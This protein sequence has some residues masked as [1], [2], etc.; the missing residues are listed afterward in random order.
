MSGNKVRSLN[1]NRDEA[2]TNLKYIHEVLS[3]MVSYTKYCYNI[4][5]SDIHEVFEYPTLIKQKWG[6]S[7]LSEKTFKFLQLF[8][9]SWLSY[10]TNK[11]FSDDPVFVYFDPEWHELIKDKLIPCL[12]SMEKDFELNKISFC[13]YKIYYRPENRP[14]EQ[15]ILERAQTLYNSLLRHNI[16][17][18]LYLN[19][20]KD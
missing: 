11:S 2:L 18:K 14:N 9:Q 17:Q 7:I 8:N 6:S 15:D 4:L 12:E 1:E 3:K 13:S 16:F 19:M 5:D 10:R 20:D